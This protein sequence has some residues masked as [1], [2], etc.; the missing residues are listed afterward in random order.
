MRLKKFSI[1][2]IIFSHIKIFPV[3]IKVTQ[4]QKLKGILMK[5]IYINRPSLKNGLLFTGYI[6]YDCSSNNYR[7]WNLAGLH[8]ITNDAKNS[9]SAS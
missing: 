5:K 7:F 4:D 8:L 1:T 3:K 9:P 2:R 6:D